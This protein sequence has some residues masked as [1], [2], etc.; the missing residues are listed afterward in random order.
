MFRLKCKSKIYFPFF[1][2][3]TFDPNSKLQLTRIDG[4]DLG[5]TRTYDVIRKYCVL[6]KQQENTDNIYD[7]CIDG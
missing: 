2:N 6:P 4:L 5:G 1:S 7:K 3:R